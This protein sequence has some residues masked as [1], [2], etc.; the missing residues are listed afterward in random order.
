GRRVL[1]RRGGGTAARPVRVLQAPRG[2]RRGD[3]PAQGPEPVKVAA[4]QHDICWEA[5]AATCA[6]VAPMIAGAAAT[7]ARL[8]VLTEMYSTGFTMAAARVAEPPDGPSTTF[9]AD[10]AV[11][12]GIWLCASVA[13]ADPTRLRPVNRL[14][15][16]GPDGQQHHYDKI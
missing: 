2:H 9:L 12:H 16:V 4:V 1:R 11:A 5:P 10:Q 7:G 3:H 14:V 8:V 15:L 13:T 6:R